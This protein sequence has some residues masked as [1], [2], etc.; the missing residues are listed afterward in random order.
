MILKIGK[1]EYPI[2]VANSFKQRLFGLMGKKDIDYGMLFPNCNS[3]HTFFMK[4]PIDIVGLDINNEIIY[5]HENLDKNQIIKINNEQNKTSIL[6]L[7][8]N[9]SK[10][11]K[12]GQILLFKDEDII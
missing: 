12:I 6:E 4:E 7:P 1:N 8:K 3:I 11:L 9:A 2:I 5:K 10:K